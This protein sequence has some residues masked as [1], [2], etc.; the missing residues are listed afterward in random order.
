MVRLSLDEPP[1]LLTLTILPKCSAALVVGQ[2]LKQASQIA[3]KLAS[4]CM[5]L[6]VYT[7]GSLL[8]VCLLSNNFWLNFELCCYG[9]MASPTYLP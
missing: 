1:F 9:H 5:Q 6:A 8:N 3:S 2:N 4:H 7:A